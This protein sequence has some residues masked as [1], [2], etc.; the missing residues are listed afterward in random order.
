M[1]RFG[2]TRASR[3]GAWCLAL[4]L[5][6]VPAAGAA[7]QP[8]EPVVRRGHVADNLYLAGGTVDVNVQADADVV[9]AGSRVSVDGRIEGDVL[10]AGG[11]TTISGTVLDDVRVV[12]GRV[13]VNAEIAGD[14]L[15]AGGRV[16]LAGDARVG[17]NAWLAGGEV[18]IAG[19]VRGKLRA[20]GG[21]V[22]IAGPIDGDVEVEAG[23]LELLPGARI[24]GNLSYRSSR[25]ADIA[26]DARVA[27]RIDFER[28]D[29]P[30]L[31]R[32]L[33]AAG[34]ILLAGL[35]VAGIAL[36]LSFPVFTQGAVRAIRTDSW[37]SL[38]LG[39][40]LLV[41]LPVAAGALITTLLGAVLGLAIL[42]VYAV[43]L[44]VAVTTVAVFLGDVVTRRMQQEPTRGLAVLSLLIGMLFLAVLARVPGVGMPLLVVALL[45]G[46]GAASLV[47]FRAYTGRH[48]A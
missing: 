1:Q 6:L 35:T 19:P 9:V 44:L 37:A 8:G 28:V 24:A 18:E 38:G 31:H 5:L 46:L 26:P 40:A 41:A 33:R 21:T 32:V 43:A 2:G 3:P 11:E 34:L 29:V 42:A 25:E 14:L 4:V 48:P 13:A 36:V 7:Q 17:G 47:A 20:A 45:F 15:A 12:G 30:P 39:I 22:R 16:E 23:Q 10:A 27:G